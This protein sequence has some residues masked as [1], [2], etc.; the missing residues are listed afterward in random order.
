MHQKAERAA[1][2][3]HHV[4]QFYSE[5]KAVLIKQ[6]EQLVPLL[7]RVPAST[8]SAREASQTGYTPASR[9]NSIP[10]TLLEMQVV[11]TYHTVRGF[12][13]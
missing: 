10:V 2:I 4:R 5:I 12:M 11:T 9:R 13:R 8:E 6:R 1:R 3:M 7:Q